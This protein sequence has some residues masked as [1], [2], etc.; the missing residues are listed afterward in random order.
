MGSAFLGCNIS[1]IQAGTAGPVASLLE[2]MPGKDTAGDPSYPQ[3]PVMF[4]LLVSPQ[5][6]HRPRYVCVERGAPLRSPWLPGPGQS[7]HPSR[8]LAFLGAAPNLPP[9]PQGAWFPLGAPHLG[10][11]QRVSSCSGQDP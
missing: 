6:P 7:L 9:A 4:C 1:G 10:L 2:G 5:R 8:G 3:S 11:F